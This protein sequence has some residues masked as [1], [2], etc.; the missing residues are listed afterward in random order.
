MFVIPA[1]ALTGLFVVY[2]AVAT[3]RVSLLSWSGY[4]PQRYVGFQNFDE[5][6]HDGDAIAATVHSLEFAVLTTVITVG[7]GAVVAVAIDRK[8][9]GARV[10]QFIIFLPVILPSTFIALAWANGYDPIFGWFT[11]VSRWFGLNQDLLANRSTGIIAVSLAYI[12][13][14]TGFAMI[15][16]L[17]ALGD[18]SPEIHEA[19]TLDSAT[20]IKRATKI[21]LPLARDAIA[22]VALLQLIWGFTNFDFVFAMVNGGPGSSTDVASTFVFYQAFA[23]QRFG[24]AAAAALVTSALLAVLAMLFLTVFKPRGIR[25]AG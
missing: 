6:I 7:V 8:V 20:R 19:A 2:P 14:N 21:S 10:F 22:T 3:I 12:L 4:G 18:I 9:R 23:N 16:I 5:L 15:I 17:A 11:Q 13:Q 25:R 24:Y 1:L